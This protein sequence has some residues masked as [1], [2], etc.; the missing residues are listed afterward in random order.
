MLNEVPQK[1]SPS[2]MT[3]KIINSISGSTV[4]YDSTM[5]EVSANPSS[6]QFWADYNTKA[7]GDENWSTGRL[8]FNSANAGA[9]IEVTYMATGTLA[10]IKSNNYPSWWTDYGNGSD[11]DFAPTSSIT[12]SGFKQYKSVYIPSG[13]TVTVVGTLYIKCQGF[14][15]NAGTITAPACGASGGSGGSGT[16]AGSVGGAG[17]SGGAGGAGGAGY[18]SRRGSGGAGGALGAGMG[19]ALKDQSSVFGAWLIAPVLTGG[20]GGGGGG[21]GSYT[22]SDGYSER[23]AS[24]GAGGTGGGCILIVTSSFKNTGTI[25]APGGAGSQGNSGGSAYGGGGG[26]GAGGFVGVVTVINNDKGTISVPGGNGGAKGGSSATAGSAGSDGT[27]V[28]E[29]LGVSL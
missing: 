12:L 22:D 4:T 5:T 25:T 9:M 1:S 18:G 14:F 11:G 2:T 10:S 20:A 23:T 6:G 29:T 24:G 3:V 19:V 16:G 26:G 17:A 7:D 8:L 27:V 15:Y 13:V 21:G 28:V